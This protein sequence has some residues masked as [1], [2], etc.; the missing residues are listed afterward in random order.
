[1]DTDFRLRQLKR[2]TQGLPLNDQKYCLND[3]EKLFSEGF[4]LSR[5]YKIYSEERN[6]KMKTERRRNF[7]LTS[8]SR[9]V[10]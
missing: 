1:M 9:R 8:L 3:S 4:E 7:H 2:L 10:A 5:E 6:L